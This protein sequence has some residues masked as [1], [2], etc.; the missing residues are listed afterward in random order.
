MDDHKAF[1][2]YVKQ[3]HEWNISKKYISFLFMEH[4]S[5]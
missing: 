4:M 1:V 3:I 5:H 2:K